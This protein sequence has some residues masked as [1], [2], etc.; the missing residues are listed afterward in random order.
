MSDVPTNPSP[1]LGASTPL[2]PPSS[3]LSL[4]PV[5]TADRAALASLLNQPALRRRSFMPDLNELH[6]LDWSTRRRTFTAALDET[7]IGA[8]ELI[9]DDD[10]PDAWELSMGLDCAGGVGGRCVS[11][12][13]FYAFRHLGARE[14]WFWVPRNNVAMARIA[15][16]FS[17]LKSHAVHHTLGPPADV[18]ELTQDRW[19]ATHHEAEAHYLS[20]PI[21]LRDVHS[22][23]L[24]EASG[25][26]SDA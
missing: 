19:Q 4:R 20:E 15:A 7:L 25:F 1:S 17:F 13:L 18:Y 11:A 21:E 8:V 10:E 22:R 2:E 12:V 26:S 23:W 24:G 6:P 3:R 14:V 16:R 5:E 9:R